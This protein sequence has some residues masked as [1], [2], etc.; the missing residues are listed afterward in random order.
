M[1][2]V[3]IL[4]NGQPLCARSATRRGPAE[5]KGFY[6]YQMDDGGIILHNPKDGAIKLATMMLRNIKEVQNDP[7]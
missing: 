2:T 6:E 4:I 7:L 3:A 5:K 1:I